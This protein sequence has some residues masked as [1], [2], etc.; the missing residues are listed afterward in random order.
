MGQEGAYDPTVTWQTAESVQPN[1]TVGSFDIDAYEVTVS[2]FAEYWN[3]EPVAHPEP[4]G[5]IE[6][7]GTEAIEWEAG[8]SVTAP[9]TAAERLYCNRGVAGRE[10]D[11]VNCVDWYTALAFCVWDAGEGGGGRLPTEAEWE[12][13]DEG[14]RWQKKD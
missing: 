7:P 8:W 6:Y 14:A 1:I 9:L 10:G 5:M 4:S 12:Y 2:R 13:A 11:P 3:T